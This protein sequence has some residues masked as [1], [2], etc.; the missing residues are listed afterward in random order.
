MGSTGRTIIF[1]NR[2]DIVEINRY[3][4]ESSGGFHNRLDNLSNPGSLEWVLEAIQHPL[5]GLDLYPTIAEKASILS[6]VIT[7]SHVFYDGNKR[8]A[9]S[10]LF[11]FLQVNGYKLDVKYDEIIDVILPISSSVNIEF[12]FDEYLN[13]VRNHMTLIS[14]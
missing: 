12:T 4:I 10:L 1:P 6:W 5:F 9:T 3:H 8:T 7:V 11:I 13:W 2:K 14:S